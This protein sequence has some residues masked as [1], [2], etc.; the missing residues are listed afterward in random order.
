M[1]SR[2]KDTQKDVGLLHAG[3]ADPRRKPSCGN[4]R[5]TL[6]ETKTPTVLPASTVTIKDVTRMM[7][8]VTRVTPISTMSMR[9]Q[10]D[11][12]DS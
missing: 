10:S 4:P 8:Q 6:M 5:N 1:S 11:L 7:F 12:L 2:N 3:A 9:G